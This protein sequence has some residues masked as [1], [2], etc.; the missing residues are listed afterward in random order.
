[1]RFAV[2]IKRPRKEFDFV[3]EKIASHRAGQVGEVFKFD[4]AER[5]RLLRNIEG[6][7]GRRVGA[8]SPSKTILSFVMFNFGW[9]TM[10]AGA[11]DGSVVNVTS[12]GPRRVRK[13]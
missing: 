2:D 4:R 6:H 1:M 12:H 13:C 7:R 8:D 10:M 5:D 11:P 9:L 3:P